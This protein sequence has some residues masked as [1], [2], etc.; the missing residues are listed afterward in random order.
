L[1][2]RRRKRERFKIR[3]RF[4]GV[5]IRRNINILIASSNRFS[6]FKS[7]SRNFIPTRFVKDFRRTS[8]RI[9]FRRR[10]VTEIPKDKIRISNN[11]R[12]ESDFGSNRS[13][14]RIRRDL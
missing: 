2:D 13:R 14:N 11:L 6:V 10:S 7:S 1:I 12:I 4:I 9:K 3:G 8:K 5:V